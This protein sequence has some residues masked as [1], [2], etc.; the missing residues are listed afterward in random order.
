MVIVASSSLSASVGFKGCMQQSPP[1]FVTAVR[2]LVGYTVR[3]LK[4][5]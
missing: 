5:L 3:K 2:T 1:A 4:T